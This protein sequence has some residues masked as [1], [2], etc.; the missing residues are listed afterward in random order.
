MTLKS[1]LP[2]SVPQNA[3]P[4]I[5]YRKLSNPYLSLRGEDWKTKK[6][7][8]TT[9]EYFCSI[10]DLVMHAASEEKTL[11]NAPRTSNY[12]FH[13]D[14]LTKTSNEVTDQWTKEQGVL[15]HWIV[16]ELGCDA[17]TACHDHAVRNTPEPMPLDVSLFSDLD[18]GIEQCVGCASCLNRCEPQKLS[19][20]TP[21]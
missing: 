2:S 3:P 12:F 8:T 6:K 1:K 18:E 11:I 10:I 16:P 5:C 7:S 19:P 9:F 21:S 13:H 4:P 20:F 15:K 17:G 14:V